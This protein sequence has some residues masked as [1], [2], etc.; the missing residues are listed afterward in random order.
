MRHNDTPK[1][2]KKI[3]HPL[4]TCCHIFFFLLQTITLNGNVLFDRTTEGRFPEVKEVKQLIRDALVPSKDLGHSDT[5]DR[6]EV[7][8]D[9]ER[10]ELDED[11]AAA[12]RR[13]FG[14]F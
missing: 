14:V 3:H 8:T 5:P 13:M 6:K 7:V 4:L 2:A 10:P 12:Q 9:V 1:H 11:D